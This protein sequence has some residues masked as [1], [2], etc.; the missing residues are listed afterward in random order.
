[1]INLSAVVTN[2]AL[3]QPYKVL[4]STVKF[5]AGGTENTT[6][7]LTFRGVV[8]VASAQDLKSF[9]QA[10]VIRGGIVI[11]GKDQ[12]LLTRK[13]PPK[14]LADIVVWKGEQYRV[15]Q[16]SPYGSYGFFKSVASRILGA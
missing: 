6:A 5:V 13:G 2:P 10:D 7:T 3:T 12:L 11:H 1:M 15:E 9:P 16:A 14:G 8:S 4:R